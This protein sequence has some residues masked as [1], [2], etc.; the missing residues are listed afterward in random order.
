MRAHLFANL[1]LGGKLVL[2]G[3]VFVVGFVCLGGYALYMTSTIKVNGP[4]YR[5][6]V[7]QKELAAD[8]LPPTEFLIEAYL[9]TLQLRDAR[10]PAEVDGL[11]LKVQALQSDFEA[12][13]VYW[14][15]RLPESPIR[16]TMIEEAYE[17]AERY[18]QVLESQF[19]PAVRAGDRQAAAALLDSTLTPLYER[20]RT[21]TEKVAQ[22]ANDE[23]QRI[24]G[25]AAAMESRFM[26]LLFAVAAVVLAA[27]LVLCV[28][29]AAAITRPLNR[30]VALALRIA[31]G[32]L[33]DSLSIPRKD[34]IGR[35]GRALNDMSVRLSETVAAVQLNAERVASATRR[36]SESART[37]AEGAQSQASTLQET[38]AAVEELS[39]SMERVSEHARAQ[40]AAVGQGAASMAL[41][42]ESIKEVA[43]T[44]GEISDLASQSVDKSE[45]GAQAVGEVV[46]GIQRV[47]GSSEKIGGIVG[48]IADIADQTNLLALNAAIEA[49]RA[50]EHGRGFAVVADEV[51]KLA[52]RSS[53]STKEIAT[54]IKESILGVSQEVEIAN[55]SQEAMK[56]IRIYARKVQEMIATLSGSMSRQMAASS[57]LAR[58]LSSIDEM[59]Q[60]I[61]LATGEQDASARQVSAAVENVNGLTQAAAAAADR[62]SAATADLSGMAEALQQRVAQFKIRARARTAAPAR[63]DALA[64]GASTAAD[65]KARALP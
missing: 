45:E 26:L 60:S 58:A 25:R 18:F 9:T 63:A 36:I 59:S 54:L 5:Q 29:I 20:H 13:H 16:T 64:A 53:A 19:I 49:A 11:G 61:S 47:A 41:V 43:R 57:E 39:A 23:S 50:G 65:A 3:A 32:D 62:M 21:S 7:E 24:E 12:R 1:R 51:G 34:E 37:L 8:V 40:A 55:G 2:L 10:S 15:G 6:V 22:M 14:S 30:S 31:D 44:L 27:A 38:S 56:Q 35:L 42:Q 17:P 28:I 48:V 33:T 52:E 46:A 4:L